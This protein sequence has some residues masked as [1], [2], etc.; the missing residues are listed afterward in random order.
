MGCLKTDRLIFIFKMK[1]GIKMDEDTEIKTIKEKSLGTYQNINKIIAE[2]NKSNA[3]VLKDDDKLIYL[4]YEQV[5]R[6]F[7]FIKDNWEN[8]E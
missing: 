3:L 8:L 7:E 2:K 4:Y 1:G 6:L 5:I